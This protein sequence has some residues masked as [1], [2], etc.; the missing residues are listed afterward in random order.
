M[1]SCLPSVAVVFNE[2]S[3]SVSLNFNTGEWESKEY[4]KRAELLLAPVLQWAIGAPMTKQTLYLMQKQIC[5]RLMELRE[6]N[7]LRKSLLSPGSWCVE[8]PAHQES[9]RS[10]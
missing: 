5:Y 6:D 1:E 3:R 8:D 10:P 4:C 9:L 7:I 2:S